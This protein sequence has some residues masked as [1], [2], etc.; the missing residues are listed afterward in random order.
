MCNVIV[1]VRRPELSAEERERRMAVIKAAAMQLL[2]AAE[3]C[4][5]DDKN[6]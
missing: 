5:K 4:R 3:K 2:V 1:R 6:V